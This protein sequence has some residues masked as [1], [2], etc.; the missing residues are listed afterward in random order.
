MDS[1]KSQGSDE[2]SQ[3]H[4]RVAD[5]YSF[6]NRS[7]WRKYRLLNPGRGMFYDVK[8]RLPYYRSD[9]TDALTY[10]TIA[11]TIRIYFVKYAS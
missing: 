2:S 7:G 5:A 9:I 6:D 8:R 3:P 10:R 4:S 11:S 1:S